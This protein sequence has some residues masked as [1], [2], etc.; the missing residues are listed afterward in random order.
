MKTSYSRLQ[1]ADIHYNRILDLSENYFV[2]HEYPKQYV[3]SFCS[4]NRELIVSNDK[5][6]IVIRLL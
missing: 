4:I 5:H 1:D 6:A 3:I 2:L